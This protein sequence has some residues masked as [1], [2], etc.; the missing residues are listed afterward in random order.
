MPNIGEAAPLV[1]E[2]RRGAGA[3]S[4]FGEKGGASWLDHLTATTELA[5]TTFRISRRS[6]C[7]AIPLTGN[8]T[9]GLRARAVSTCIPQLAVEWRVHGALNFPIDPELSAR[10]HP[11]IWQAGENP[12]VVI[13]SGSG[14]V[15]A[16]AACDLI[17]KRTSN[18]GDHLVLAGGGARHRLLVMASARLGGDTYLIPQDQSV[19]IRLAALDAFHCCVAGSA[20]PTKRYPLRPTTYQSQRLRLLLTILDTLGRAHEGVTLREIAETLVYRGLS[21]QRAIDWKSSSQRRQTQRLIAEA[22]RMASHGY[23]GLLRQNRLRP[24]QTH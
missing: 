17:A 13:L 19:P 20:V 6:S 9:P 7:A 11:A 4:A 15:A 2:C 24:F 10:S 16:R 5:D 8:N 23:L 21:A 3:S 18:A 22:R 1:L 14:A 12:N